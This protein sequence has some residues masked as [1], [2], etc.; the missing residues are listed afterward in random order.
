MERVSVKYFIENPVFNANSEDPDQ[1]PSSTASG[2][3]LHCL[4]N[5]IFME[6]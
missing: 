2:F 1:T 3:G 6:R 4:S 5:V